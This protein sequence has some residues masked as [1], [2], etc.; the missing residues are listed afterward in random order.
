MN[1]QKTKQL[2]DC[3][4]IVPNTAFN[5]RK[6]L[7]LNSLPIV[8]GPQ[9][10]FSKFWVLGPVNFCRIGFF[11]ECP[12]IQTICRMFLNYIQHWVPY[13][14]TTQ[15]N[16]LSIVRWPQRKFS[17]CWALCAN[18]LLQK[19]FLVHV[20]KTEKFV[21]CFWVIPNTEFN[22]CQLLLFDGLLIVRWPQRVF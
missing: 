14:S 20:Q 16:S 4:L 22:K 10:I 2:V 12:E 19:C 15:L 13:A 18:L 7:L 6:L 5:E 9:S 17:K 21:E 3:F 8:R 11:G 1:V